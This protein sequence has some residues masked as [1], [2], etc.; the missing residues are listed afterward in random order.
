MKTIILVRHIKSDWSN[1]LHDIERP[2]RND[3][4]EDA[5]LIA[6]VIAEKSEVPQHIFSSPALRT[7][8]TA[9]CLSAGWNL[10]VSISESIYECAASDILA[11][12]KKIP[13]EY[14]H[15]AIVCHN[16]AITDFVNQYSNSYLDNMPTSGAVSITFD[17]D[18]WPSVNGQGEMNWVLRPKELRVGRQ[19]TK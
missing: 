13:K 2:V 16:P 8:Q 6:D 4:R 9:Q 19:D 17:T 1:L 5:L 11:M 7:R 14:D 3:R 18:E 15:V 10:S 12:I